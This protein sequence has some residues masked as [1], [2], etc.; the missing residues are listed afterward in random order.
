MKPRFLPEGIMGH[1]AGEARVECIASHLT[2]LTSPARSFYPTSPRSGIVFPAPVRAS[3]GTAPGH[4]LPSL[5][6]RPLIPRVHLAASRD[7]LI[8][9]T[10]GEESTFPWSLSG[11]F[12][13]ICIG[14]AL[15][16]LLRV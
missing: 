9:P 13:A 7:L 16:E 11:D 10:P 1:R 15:R 2:P 5:R 12:L 8:H 4:F 14:E 6:S 3:S